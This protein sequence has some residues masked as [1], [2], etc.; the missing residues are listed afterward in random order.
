MTGADA[1]RLWHR[2]RDRAFATALRTSFLSYGHRTVV[3][4]PVRLKGEDRIALGSDVFIGAGSWLQTIRQEHDDAPLIE[5]GD[6]TSMSGS[7]VVS[8]A[9]EIKIGKAV[10]FA[11]NV[12]VS[13]H[14]HAYADTG[15]PV[16]DQ[17]VDAVAPVSIGDG[18]WLAQNVVVCPGVSIGRGAVVA[19][20]SVVRTDVPD[21]SLA[22]GAPAVVRRQF[23]RSPSDAL[24]VGSGPI[25]RP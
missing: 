4:P 8:A 5:I 24:G 18:A 19:A 12:Y 15:I 3:Q 10:L 7:C 14:N 6:R 11:R 2:A 17:G 13:D 21:W 23:D 1:L 25:G 16:L 22:A 9:R 20:N